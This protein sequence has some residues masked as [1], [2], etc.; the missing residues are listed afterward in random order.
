MRCGC[1]FPPD[2]N[3]EGKNSTT[4][5][6]FAI[7]SARVTEPGD[8]VEGVD[9]EPCRWV[10]PF[11]AAAASSAKASVKRDNERSSGERRVRERVTHR[12]WKFRA[13]TPSIV[14]P[15]SSG[16]KRLAS[17]SMQP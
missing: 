11:S 17:T 12:Q 15:V 10:Q 16:Q 5:V 13:W 14:P 3:C 7:Q 1:W 2:A 4:V 9:G 8:A 6:P